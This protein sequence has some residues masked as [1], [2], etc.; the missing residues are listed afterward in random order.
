[1]STTDIT[2]VCPLCGDELHL[3]S[4]TVADVWKDNR[5][6]QLFVCRHC[7]YKQQR[8]R[9]RKHPKDKFKRLILFHDRPLGHFL[10]W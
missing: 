9:K 3:D 1:M 5:K 8:K 2:K 6:Q 7:A 4:F 10:L